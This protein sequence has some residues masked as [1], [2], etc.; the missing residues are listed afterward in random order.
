[1][2][3]CEF[4]WLALLLVVLQWIPTGVAETRV[5]RSTGDSGSVEFSDEPSPGATPITVPAPATYKAPALPKPT[6]AQASRSAKG[7]VYR[8]LQMIEPQPG[9][10]VWNNQGNLQVRFALDPEL[11]TDEG[12]RLVVV[13][14]GQPQQPVAGNGYELH[15]LERG[16]HD[17]RGRVVDRGGRVL[18]ESAASTL[19]LQQQSVNYPARQANQPSPPPTAPPRT[20]APPPSGS[21]ARGGIPGG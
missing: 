2:K 3:R 17:V 10:T 4:T 18:I 19:Y 15:D 9:A 7:G 20:P 12:H 1:M 5:Y 16:A 6:A 8:S 13:L 21:G 11:R 14:D